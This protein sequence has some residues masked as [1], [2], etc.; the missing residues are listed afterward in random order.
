MC[1][2]IGLQQVAELVV[3]EGPRYGPHGQQQN[4]CG[5]QNES[6]QKSGRDRSPPQC[7]DASAYGSDQAASRS[8]ARQ[9][10]GKRKCNRDS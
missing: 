9:H 2:G 10:G 6:Q 1:E 4:P 3:D 5:D 7:V 8:R